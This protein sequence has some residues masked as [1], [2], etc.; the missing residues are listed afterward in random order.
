[1]ENKQEGETAFP[2]QGFGLWVVYVSMHAKCV[3][4]CARVH[5]HVRVHACSVRVCACVSAC[6]Y[7]KEH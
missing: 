3:G 6:V 7:G 1:M 5:V 4:G 2:G